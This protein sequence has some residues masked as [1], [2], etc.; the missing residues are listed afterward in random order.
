MSNK[1]PEVK[2]PQVKLDFATEFLDFIK[3]YGVIGLA[4]GIIVG[5]AVQ[6]LVKSI[7]DNLLNPLIGLIPK[8]S[9]LDALQLQI[10]GATFTYG[11]FLKDLINF[12]ALMALVFFLIKFFISKFMSE[13]DS[14]H[15]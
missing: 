12:I 15:V 8:L 14:K 4:I 13:S 3:K 10:M 1:M 6:E 5:G 2:M 9:S 11:A 7:V